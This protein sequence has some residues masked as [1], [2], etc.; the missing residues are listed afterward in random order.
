MYFIKYRKKHLQT[1]SGKKEQKRKGFEIP[2]F[3]L[4]YY[5]SIFFIV[6]IIF[7]YFFYLFFF[8]IP[9]FLNFSDPMD[10]TCTLYFFVPV[11]LC[12]FL[13]GAGVKTLV[14]NLAKNLVKNLSRDLAK[15]LGVRLLIA[16][17]AKKN[18]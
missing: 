10:L 13:G 6:F 7:F 14:E 9:A 15:N 2:F 8:E 16:N 18:C 1:I 5:F 3:Y 17:I 12:T 11:G 4:F